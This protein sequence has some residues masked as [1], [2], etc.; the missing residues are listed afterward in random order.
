MA[1]KKGIDKYL[2]IK[3]SKTCKIK[4]KY[5]K[6]TNQCKSFSLIHHKTCG[7]ID[8]LGGHNKS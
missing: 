2:K 3:F 6:I 4:M 8:T 7:A 5:V 1:L